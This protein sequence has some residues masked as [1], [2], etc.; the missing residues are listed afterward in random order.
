MSISKGKEKKRK[1]KKDS[2]GQEISA[3]AIVGFLSSVKMRRRGFSS[4][5]WW[6][7]DFSPCGVGDGTEKREAVIPSR[8]CPGEGVVVLLLCVYF[9]AP[10][11]LLLCLCCNVLLLCVLLPGRARSWLANCAQGGYYTAAIAMRSSPII[12]F[13][14]DHRE[15]PHSC[16]PTRLSTLPFALPFF[17]PPRR[18]CRAEWIELHLHSEQMDAEKD[19]SHAFFFCLPLSHLP[20]YSGFFF[21]LISHHLF[22]PCSSFAFICCVP[23]VFCA[24]VCFLKS[25]KECWV[26]GVKKHS[27]C[28]TLRR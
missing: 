5:W 26:N 19:R 24:S 11:R 2:L 4:G 7:R 12:P 20:P 17:L 23:P 22:F 1:R 14:R 28:S 16:T 18:T 9:P 6:E 21:S 13:R 3:R 27:I 15:P 10:R 8:V 25:C